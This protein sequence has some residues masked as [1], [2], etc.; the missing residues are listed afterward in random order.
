MNAIH[1]HRRRMLAQAT[2][3]QDEEHAAEA[4]PPTKRPK[5]A[6]GSIKKAKSTSALDSIL[7]STLQLAV[8]STDPLDFAAAH[9]KHCEAVLSGV[10]AALAPVALRK[11]ASAPCPCVPNDADASATES[12]AAWSCRG[13]MTTD[14]RCLQSSADSALSCVRCGT[15]EAAV[16]MVALVRQKNCPYA[17]DATTVADTPSDKKLDATTASMNGPEEPDHRR[18]RLVTAGGGSVISVHTA[19]RSGV[20]SAQSAVQKATVEQLA[21]LIEGDGIHSRKRR[22]V[23]RVLEAA[24]DQIGRLD[25]R[26]SKAVRIATNKILDA[27]MRH[28]SVCKN[29][30]CQVTLSSRSSAMVGLCAASHVLG[31]L[32]CTP[33]A[34][35]TEEMQKLPERSFSDAFSRVKGLELSSVGS[36]SKM[37]VAASIAIIAQWTEGEEMIP[38][39]PSVPPASPLLRLPA[40]LVGGADNFGKAPS[41]NLAD[42]IA[43]KIR[44]RLLATTQL[45][46]TEAPVRDACLASLAKPE[47]IAFLTAQTLPSDVIA[48]AML[49]AFAKYKKTVDSVKKITASILRLHSVEATAV[50]TFSQAILHVFDAIEEPEVAQEAVLYPVDVLF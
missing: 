29:R 41:R 11:S 39:G 5:A 15:V 9:R 21:K 49:S 24:F 14:T 40:A 38:C 6:R 47:M 27:S 22:A 31:E 16:S 13:C 48:L 26:I 3:F 2:V 43:F 45:V 36:C 10:G 12:A 20:V 50:K 34:E 37:S 7:G 33:K 46:N 19:K 32:A 42:E 1:M 28:E 17:E 44:D 30:E 23:L 4:P 25:V 8:D 18:R 35:R